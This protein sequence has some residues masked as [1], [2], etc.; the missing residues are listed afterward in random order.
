MA[1]LSLIILAQIDPTQHPQNGNLTGLVRF[2][3]LPVA[4]PAF[5]WLAKSRERQGRTGVISAI[6]SL[7]EHINHINHNYPQ[8]NV[9]I[10][11]I[12]SIV[13]CRTHTCSTNGLATSKQQCPTSG[14]CHSSMPLQL[15]VTCIHTL[16]YFQQRRQTAHTPVGGQS[17]RARARVLT[18][19][20]PL[21]KT[22]IVILYTKHPIYLFSTYYSQECAE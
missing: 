20:Q 12:N 11:Q 7:T 19:N 2:Q 22:S 5:D 18:C 16:Q 14:S 21:C 9:R 1:V 10:I 8:P 15:A 4:Q 17:P 6:H 13:F 3:E